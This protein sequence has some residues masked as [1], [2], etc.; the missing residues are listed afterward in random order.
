M[1]LYDGGDATQIL[2][3]RHPDLLAGIRGISEEATTGV[4]RL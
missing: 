2:H 3:G 1:V 4:N